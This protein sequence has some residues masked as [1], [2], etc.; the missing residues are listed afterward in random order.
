MSES[1]LVA[2]SVVQK[3]SGE[4]VTP[5]LVH[6]SDSGS[7]GARVYVLRH[8]L[9]NHSYAVKCV[10][11]S[12]VSL[13]DEVARYGVLQSYFDK[14]LPKIL[15][16][17][18]VGDYEVLV[19]EA[20]GTQ[21]LHN[22]IQHST[23]PQSVMVSIWNDVLEQ[24]SSNVWI[25]SKHTP[26]EPSLSPRHFISRY[27]R[28]TASLKSLH[29]GGVPLSEHFE[30]PIILNGVKY[31]PLRG[32]LEDVLGVG[33]PAFGVVC[34]GDPQPSNIIVSDDIQNW[35]MVDWEWCGRHHDW[36]AMFSHLY[37][38]WPSRFQMLNMPAELTVTDRGIVINYSDAIESR[39]VEFQNQT[40]KVFSNMSEDPKADAKD[41]NKYLSVLY[42][43][44]TRF[45][46][47][48]NREHF[49]PAILAEAVKTANTVST[50]V[51]ESCFAF[52]S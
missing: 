25:A 32:L 39:I 15:L 41:I 30:K 34:H 13:F 24:L 9:T 42:F 44:E 52:Q 17:D 3:L 27:N 47:Y 21:T 51:S 2:M 12:R 11:S 26:Y 28:V 33:N 40:R 43:G 6:M 36:R 48:W 23:L 49:L 4:N 8:P 19:S 29:V 18:N 20:H 1:L 22:L 37:G 14:H 50:G 10:K 35:C 7:S 45:V 5:E 38:W 46:K 31:P 16:V